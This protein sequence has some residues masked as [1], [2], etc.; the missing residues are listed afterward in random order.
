MQRR[1]FLKLAPAAGAAATALPL[2]QAA[3]ADGHAHAAALAAAQRFAVGDITLTAISDGGFG[4]TADALNGITTDEAAAI[5][6]SQFIDPATF[7][8]G[9][10]AFLIET[11]DRKILVDCGTGGLFGPDVNSFAANLAA[12]GIGPDQ[13]DAVLVTHLHPDHIGGML[14]DNGAVF[15]NAELVVHETDRSFWGDESN[16]TAAPEQLQ[17]FAARAR[18]TLEAYGDR[19]VTFS[20]ED[21]VAPGVSAMPLPGHTPGHSGYMLSSGDDSLLIWADI[22]HVA[23]VQLARPEV[24]ISFDIDPD[25][26]AKSRAAILDRVAADRTLVAG[27]HIIFPG[28]A[29]IAKAETGYRAVP[30]RFDY[31]ATL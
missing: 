30:A 1:D 2:A 5:M 8:A 23:P 3:R 14:D 16:F 28:L 4:I 26:A 21:D 24:T 29:H 9:V 13:I 7:R 31:A 25:Q 10:N 19:I 12:T 27:S 11:G 18:A 22:V 15:P 17:F 20:G 6:E